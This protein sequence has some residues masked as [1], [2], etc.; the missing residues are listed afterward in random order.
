VT[1]PFEDYINSLEGKEDINP[2]EVAKDLF[3]LH[4]QEIGTRDAKI[5]QLNSGI[6]D[7]D[8]EIANRDI[9]IRDWKAMNLDLSLQLPGS[10]DNANNERVEGEK[11]DGSTIRISDLLNPN[12]RNPRNA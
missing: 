3:G 6:A 5:E 8:A 2:I 7:K 11:P 1:N 12:V 9:Q 4:A 10:N